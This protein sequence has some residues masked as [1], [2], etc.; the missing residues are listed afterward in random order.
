M[1]YWCETCGGMAFRNEYQMRKHLEEAH[2]V[3]TVKRNEIPYHIYYRQIGSQRF[4]VIFEC[5]FCGYRK[6]K[7]AESLIDAHAICEELKDLAREH[8]KEH[9]KYFCDGREFRGIIAL[10]HYVDVTYHVH[11]GFEKGMTRKRVF[12]DGITRE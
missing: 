5:P 7:K 3:G 8:S 9:L 11:I 1:M 2:N 12:L 6:E 10:L 4:K